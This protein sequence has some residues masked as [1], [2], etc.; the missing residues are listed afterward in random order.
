MCNLETK[1]MKK[2]VLAIAFILPL[3]ACTTQERN[4]T[5]GAGVGTAAGAAITGDATGAIAGGLI[6]GGI[7]AA[8]ANR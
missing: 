2:A 5:I 1:I 6:G 7:G 8:T 4:A 3:G